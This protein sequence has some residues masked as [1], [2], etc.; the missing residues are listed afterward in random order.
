MP[1]NDFA[2]TVNVLHERRAVRALRHFNIFCFFSLARKGSALALSRRVRKAMRKGEK[3]LCAGPLRALCANAL[4]RLDISVH[5]ARKGEKIPLR[6]LCSGR[7]F[8][9]LLALCSFARP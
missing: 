7:D 8:S 5:S 6:A 1:L 2:H 3:S 4:L 9:P